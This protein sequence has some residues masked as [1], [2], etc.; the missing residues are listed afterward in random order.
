MINLTPLGVRLDRAMMMLWVLFW[1]TGAALFIIVTHLL[2]FGR[3][4]KFVLELLG[5]PSF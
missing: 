3:A 1:T 5:L 2:K 4:F